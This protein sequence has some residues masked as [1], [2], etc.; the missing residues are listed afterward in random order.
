MQ[1]DV[2][3]FLKNVN[4][5]LFLACFLIFC[6]IL[7]YRKKLWAEL[8]IF[9]CILDFKKKWILVKK[10]KNKKKKKTPQNVETK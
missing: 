9:E 8:P 4:L 1:L 5:R 6:Q 3:N 2:I 10:Q 7:E